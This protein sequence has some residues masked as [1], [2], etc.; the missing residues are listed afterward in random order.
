[1]P[2]SWRP[3][4]YNELNNGRKVRGCNLTQSNEA[5]LQYLIAITFAYPWGLSRGLDL[6]MSRAR[7]SSNACSLSGSVFSTS[8]ELHLTN[9]D[10]SSCLRV[11]CISR[12]QFRQ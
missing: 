11:T 4:A 7:W 9:C 3:N 2:T 8:Q 1:M 6:R 10:T 12:R 5:F